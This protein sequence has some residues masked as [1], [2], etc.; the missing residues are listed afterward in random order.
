MLGIKLTNSGTPLGC[1]DYWVFNQRLRCFIH[2]QYFIFKVISALHWISI[3]GT[4]DTEIEVNYLHSSCTQCERNQ[5]QPLPSLLVN[6]CFLFVLFSY[7]VAD[8]WKCSLSTPREIQWQNTKIAERVR[9]QSIAS[10]VKKSVAKS[11]NLADGRPSART[12]LFCE[13][14]CPFPP[15][16]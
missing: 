9:V 4:L 10:R 12:A 1:S 14:S 3:T 16:H 7:I 15:G 13:D 6:I 8:W 5:K 2:I 11:S